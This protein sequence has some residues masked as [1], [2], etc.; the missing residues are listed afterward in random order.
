MNM[1]KLVV[2]KFGD[3][4]FETGFAV[5]LQIGMDGKLPDIEIIGRLPS[6]TQLPVYYDHWQLSYRR[7]SNAFR[8]SANKVQV[9][10]VS[11][12][13]DCQTTAQILLLHFNTWLQSEPFRPLREKL[14]EHLSLTDAVRV[15]LQTDNCQL[16]KM[17]WQAWDLLERFNHAEIA[18]TSPSYERYEKLR[19]PNLKVK[20]LAIIGSSQG[21]DTQ[22]DQALLQNLP[23]ADIT[24]LVEPQRQQLNDQLWENNWDILFFA[25]HSLS[26]NDESGR[27]FLNQTDSLNMGELRY[28]LQKSVSSGLHLAIFN[29]CDGLGLAR[30][31]AQLQIPQII[32]MREPVPDAVASEF[33]KYFLSEYASG[34]SFYQ[35]VRQ[36]R[37][38]LQGLEDKFPAA[39]WL[40]MICQNNPAQ[41]PLTWKELTFLASPETVTLPFKPLY[42]GQSPSLVSPQKQ[43]TLA[44]LSCV[45]ITAI[46]SGLRF[47]G[48]LE[49]AELKSFDQML[50]LRSMLAREQ[51]DDRL[52]IVT[53][54]DVDLAEQRRQDKSLKGTSISDKSLNLLLE[55]LQ[56]YQPRAIGLD[57]YRDF[58]AQNRDL[59]N[60]LQQTPNL[61]AI[62]K[63]GYSTTNTSGIEPPPEIPK[64]EIKE[65]LGFS[66]FIR[67]RDGVVRR[68]LLFMN[69]EPA[70]LCTTPYSF[71]LQLAFHYLQSQGINQADIVGNKLKIGK[72]VFKLLESRIGGYQGIDANGGQILLNWR[73]SERVAQEVTL[74][75]V[76]SGQVNE[77]AFKDKIILV[78]VIAKGDLQDY[79]PTPYGSN[80]DTQMAG[81][82]IH[83]NMLSEILSAVIDNRPLLQTW[84]PGIEILWVLCWSLT[85]GILAWWFKFKPIP[86][87]IAIITSTGILYVISLGMLV[88][89][90]W[91]PL[92]PSAIALIST[93]VVGGRVWGV[94][95]L[96]VRSY[97]LGV[98]S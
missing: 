37:Q 53:I 87:L 10:N 89:G 62:C 15:I 28:A 11:V 84:T 70:S 31:L 71:N 21:I 73:A 95:D 19:K 20:I 94:G 98:M 41:I 96:R 64:Q 72:A 2:L 91:I 25:G 27:I 75:E 56:Q 92:V 48:I 5:T 68:H 35:A 36:A 17:P 52:L 6:A 29:S 24:F 40:P 90:Y 33:L 50:W 26:H 16:L 65:R 58:P 55:K 85:G 30:E 3:G 78:G 67:D 83:A 7:L 74:R 44:L 63:G 23:D 79:F 12:T 47:L 22:A 66:D 51:P 8:L 13:N 61:I 97:E 93:A 14:L 39:T 4:S 38:R 88:S 49:N 18:L 9:T 82:T 46:I 32:F 77:S 81:V 80:A 60:K 45:I 86:I 54:D 57:I 1:G 34:T 76:L 59:I 43:V 69:Q 42:Y